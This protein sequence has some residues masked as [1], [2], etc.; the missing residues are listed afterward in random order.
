[1]VID[2]QKAQIQVGSKIPTLS[3]TQSG[4]TTGTTTGV[5]SSINYLETG[6]LLSVSPRVNTGG[7]ITLEISQEVSEAAATT[8][9]GIDSPTITRRTAQ[10]VVS[11]QS[12]EP[13]IFAGLIQKKRSFSTS[14]I[15][16]LSK[17]PIIGGAF[18]SQSFHDEQTEL[19]LIITP[20][21]VADVNNARDALDEL[22]RKM[23]ALEQVFPKSNNPANRPAKPVSMPE[24]KAEGPAE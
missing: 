3:S 11:T 23:P 20:R 22:R 10:S 21:L 4:I 9:S 24:P 8:T 13:L 7:R 17:I 5:I 18:G 1:M 6:I 15:P 14:G 2:N 16:L 19:V 12:G